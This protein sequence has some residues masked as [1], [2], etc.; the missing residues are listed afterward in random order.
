MAQPSQPDRNFPV[1]TMLFLVVG[2]GVGLVLAVCALWFHFAAKAS[3]LDQAR[4]A[5][6]ALMHVQRIGIAA[7]EALRGEPQAFAQ[8]AESG[9]R[10]R[11]DL[12]LMTDG[13]GSAGELARL[14]FKASATEQAAAAILKMA[15]E[16][17]GLA[18]TLEQLDTLAPELLAM[19]EE[20]L[21]QKT[22][23]GGTPRELAHIGRMVMLTQ[24]MSLGAH[25]FAAA[26][27]IRPETAVQL[28]RDAGTFRASVDALLDGSD[29]MKVTA[30]RNPEARVLLGEI[31]TRFATFQQA[32]A[33]MLADLPK[34]A[35]AKGAELSIFHE[36][37]E[38]ARQLAALGLG[39]GVSA[40]VSEPARLASE[41]LTHA[42]RIAKAAPNA[43][44]GNVEAFAQLEQ[45]RKIVKHNL[46][47]LA[48]GAG[49]SSTL[50]QARDKWISSDNAAG[51]IV[52][53]KPELTAYGKSL[54]QLTLL[55]PE[56]LSMSEELLSRRVEKGAAAR[57]LAA[58]GRMTMLTQRLALNAST[59]L[60]SDAISPERAFQLGR[61]ANTF[62]A[63]VDGLLDG[64]AVMQLTA[65]DD[66][67][68]RVLI[69]E[70]GRK[71]TIYNKL[72]SA[73]LE[74]LA[75]LAAAT[76][77]EST[78]RQESEEIRKLLASVER[79][80]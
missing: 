60:T 74:K 41:A 47:L 43:L 12:P 18:K 46:D 1:K 27:G 80:G 71:F 39:S 30:E 45:S 79:K 70:I 21:G 67:A 42:Q 56:L 48:K 66:P 44:Q 11:H 8:L 65:V 20:L 31:K 29:V 13:G 33:P 16:L 59:L 73:S 78:I 57:E 61:D 49:T 2:L 62:R 75:Q 37:E 9:A 26:G 64:H 7:P 77:A 15:P 10:L 38:L 36:G 34:Y 23:T 4:I 22:F 69:G 32:L 76:G 51:T 14:K 52:R 6:D 55:T 40:G 35:A 50:A 54:M 68:T 3:A 25:E 17:A 5:S 58:I 53:M 63:T 28:G 24:R 19:S 72:V